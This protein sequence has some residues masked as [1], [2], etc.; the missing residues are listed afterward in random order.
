MLLERVAC[1][2]ASIKLLTQSKERASLGRT[3]QLEQ[4]AEKK[5]DKK[6]KAS[7]ECELMIW[8][9][10]YNEYLRKKSIN[11]DHDKVEYIIP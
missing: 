11:D 3:K 1:Y 9:T 8:K 10:K 6:K 5:G 2:E 4:I 7:T